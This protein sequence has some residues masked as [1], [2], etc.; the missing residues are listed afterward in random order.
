MKSI[1]RKHDSVLVSENATVATGDDCNCF[2]DEA[3][4][5]MVSFVLEAAKSGQSVICIL[6][7][8]IDVLVLLGYCVNWADMQYK[9]HIKHWDRSVRIP[10][11]AVVVI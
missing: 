9:V 3:D 8:D 11:E 7:D 1:K 10:Q 4:M 5:T 2:H 6:S